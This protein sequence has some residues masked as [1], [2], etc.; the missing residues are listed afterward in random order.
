MLYLFLVTL[1]FKV[2]L[3]QYN[4]KCKHERV[5]LTACAYYGK[6]VTCNKDT[7]K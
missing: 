1:Y 4:S 7:L 6:Y 3:L 2:A 5:I